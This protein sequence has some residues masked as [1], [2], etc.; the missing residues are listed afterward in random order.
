MCVFV[1]FYLQEIA[2]K[3]P[4]RDMLNTIRIMDEKFDLSYKGAYAQF[5]PKAKKDTSKN[6]KKGGSKKK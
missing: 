4:K 1:L 2:D 5:A 3:R 6:N